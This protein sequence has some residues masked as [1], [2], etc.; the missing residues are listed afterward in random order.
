[1]YPTLYTSHLK[2][3]GPVLQALSIFLRVTAFTNPATVE[4]YICIFL[5]TV[6]VSN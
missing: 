2:K 6:W 3:F 1:M 4:M 5:V